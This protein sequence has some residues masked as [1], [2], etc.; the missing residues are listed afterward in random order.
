[1]IHTI[2]KDAVILLGRGGYS[3]TPR[4]QLDHMVASVQ[5][6]GRYTLVVGAMVDQGAPALP[7]ALDACAAAGAARVLLVPVFI[8]SDAN[9]HTWLAKV[10]RR[11][12]ANHPQHTM[13]IVMGVGLDDH[14]AVA[15]ALRAVLID[16]EVGA[17]LADDPPPSWERDPA[18]WSVLPAH[19]HH[20]LTCRG[21]RCTAL[22]AEACW[23]QLRDSLAAH[24]LRDE[25]ERVLT[26]ATGCLYPC[27]RGPVLVVYPDGVW[28]GD[29]TPELVERMVAE[30][31]IA[32]RPLDTHRIV[33]GRQPA[34]TE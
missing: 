19:Q 4:R 26:A 25:D 29:L 27:N 7:G 20:L 21:P 23:A 5:Q 14:P 3:A 15:Q 2:S 11:W 16:S 9:L 33:P 12:Q 13:A 10:A 32:G 24:G 30:H 31:L 34:V 1:M 17:D 28:Y 6:G 22:G 8:P 18:G